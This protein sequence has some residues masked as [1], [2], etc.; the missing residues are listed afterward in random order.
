MFFYKRL[1]NFQNIR[2]KKTSD[3]KKTQVLE[4][5]DFNNFKKDMEKYAKETISW[6]KRSNEILY[7]STWS[8]K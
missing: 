1:M 5:T 7:N 4:I 3:S 8:Q 6:G 2:H